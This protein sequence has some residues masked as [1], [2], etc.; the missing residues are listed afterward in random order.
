MGAE[1]MVKQFYGIRGVSSVIV[2]VVESGE[3]SEGIVGITAKGKR[4]TV[5]K[6]EKDGIRVIKAYDGDRVHIVV[7]HLERQ[8]IRM[9]E[10]FSF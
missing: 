8:D 1:F 6:I 10:T 7:K 5:V 3:I 2:G 9:G 4:F